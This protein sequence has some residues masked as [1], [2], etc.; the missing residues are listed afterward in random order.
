MYLEQ[1]TMAQLRS[2][3]IFYPVLGSSSS[4]SDVIHE[5]IVHRPQV[6]LDSMATDWCIVFDYIAFN[7]P[8]K[9]SDALPP[10]DV[11]V[12]SYQHSSIDWFVNETICASQLVQ[13]ASRVGTIYFYFQETTADTSGYNAAHDIDKHMV[14]NFRYYIKK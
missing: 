9:I 7:L 10:H 8:L 5:L 4:Q 1:R 13:P 2:S 6:V 12:R 11:N 3:T 14:S